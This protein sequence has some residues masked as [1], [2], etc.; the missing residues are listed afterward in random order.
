MKIDVNEYTLC[1]PPPAVLHGNCNS[2]TQAFSVV[3]SFS[4]W[5]LSGSVY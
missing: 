2:T 3:N 5:P 1:L 4:D